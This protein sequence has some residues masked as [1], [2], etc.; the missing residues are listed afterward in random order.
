MNRLICLLLM[1]MIFFSFAPNA[2]AGGVMPA[3]QMTL[4]QPCDAMQVKDM[5]CMK[6]EAKKMNCVKSC[7]PMC[8]SLLPF[9]FAPSFCL[10]FP[11]STNHPQ[12]SFLLLSKHPENLYRPPCLSA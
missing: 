4:E 12:F 7:A 5:H 10:Y 9:Y 2:L 3:E 1:P 6:V 8:P 11:P